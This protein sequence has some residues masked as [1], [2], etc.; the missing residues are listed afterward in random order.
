MIDI[1]QRK[2]IWTDFITGEKN[3]N[4]VFVIDCNWQDIPRPLLW[5]EKKEERI[6][7]IYKEYELML[8]NML[9]LN[10]D[11]IPF[12][13]MITGTEI[14]AEAFGCKV[15]RP[16]DNNPFALP[17][18]TSASDISKIKVPKLWDSSL[19]VLFE[20]ADR[21]YEKSGK[22]AIFRLPDIQSPMDIAA[23]L[24]EKTEYFVTLI[25]EPEL[26]QELSSKVF[27]L[28]TDFLNEWF[29]RYGKSFISHCPYYYMD[30]G[31]TLSEDE[32]GSVNSDI[33][34]NYFLPELAKLSDIYGGIGIHCCANSRH[35]WENFKRI[36]N[37]KLLNIFQ[38]F[39]VLKDAVKFFD[40]VTAQCHFNNG[41]GPSWEW[42]D[43]Y[44]E[45]SRY[46]INITASN[47]DEAL[48][49]CDELRTILQR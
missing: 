41:T 15:H 23:L 4:R 48:K 36:P 25:D 38:P 19:T 47:K 46:V 3:V 2:E 6:D 1:K 40:E 17:L 29:K 27:C 31:I 42:Y 34:A 33:F 26:I 5:P 37:L 44:T 14:F 8:E 20:M 16:I 43:L 24:L 49:K 21:L 28:L 35:Q 7:Y 39:D 30:K 32:I 45:K 13:D 11:R 9:W 22:Q 18:I 10:D 12:L